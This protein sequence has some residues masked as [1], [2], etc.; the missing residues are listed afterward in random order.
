VVVDDDAAIRKALQF[1]LEQEGYAVRVYA[2]AEAL[3]EEADIHADACLVVD[4]RMPGMNGLDLLEVLRSRALLMKAIL[5][6]PAISPEMRRRGS[7]Y[8]VQAFVEKPLIGSCFL[9]AVR[10]VA[11]LPPK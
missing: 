6:S 11:P 9:D 7:A 3:L 4:Y 1:A 5:I 10:S 8:G 2:S